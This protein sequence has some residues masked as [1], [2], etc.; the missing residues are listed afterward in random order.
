M[1]K[2][3]LEKEMSTLS[4]ILAWEIPWTEESGGLQSI[5]SQRI[6]HDGASEHTV[7]EVLKAGMLKWLA[8]PFSSGPHLHFVRT[9]HH[10]SCGP[11]WHGS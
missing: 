7:H 9:L 5:G 10:D 1:H 3:P 4:S 2:S 11:T 6:G 8:M